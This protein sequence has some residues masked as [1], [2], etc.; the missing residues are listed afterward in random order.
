MSHLLALD[1]STSLRQRVARGE[2]TTGTQIG[3]N[4]PAV[5][6][7]FGRVGFDW[8]VIDTEHTSISPADVRA[9]LQAAEGRGIV[10]VV[11]VPRLDPDALRL[12]LDLGAAAILCPFIE[13]AEDAEALVSACHYP[14]RGRRGWNPRRAANYGIDSADYLA[15]C[16]EGILVLAIIESARGVDHAQEI[17]A[18]PGIDGVILGPMDLTLDLGCFP[19]LEHPDYVAAYTQVRDAC[20]AEGTAFGAGA[21]DAAGS[22]ARSSET[23]LLL[24]GDEPL[25]V[26]AAAQ[27]LS[28]T[29][30][31]VG[32]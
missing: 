19:D 8:A 27:L 5:I 21:Y 31:Q 30:T 23:L 20:R 7:I 18:T 13:T 10:P 16:D 6:E 25:L 2:T 26:G 32:P 24:M 9:F 11:R 15:R 28:D 22:C 29:R 14:P 17:A 3:L 12:V 4:D 1:A